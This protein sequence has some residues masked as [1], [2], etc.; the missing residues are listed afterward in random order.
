[1]E[2][3]APKPPKMVRIKEDEPL[4]APPSNTAARPCNA[5][6]SAP[7]SGRRHT[8]ANLWAPF[9]DG[10]INRKSFLSNVHLALNLTL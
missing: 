1:M 10:M 7:F 3:H 5:E 2:K 4:S 9:P 6:P 8:I